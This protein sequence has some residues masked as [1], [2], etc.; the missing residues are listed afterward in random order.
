M[1]RQHPKEANLM[2][3]SEWKKKERELLADIARTEADAR[4]TAIT[5]TQNGAV[6]AES[7]EILLQETTSEWNIFTQVRDALQRIRLGTFG[8]Y[9]DYGRQID[10]H[11]LNAVPW[12]AYWFEHESFRRRQEE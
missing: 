2:T 9:I 3:I 12:T 6:A 8:K 10:D 4:A 5:E 11:R 7:K 1:T